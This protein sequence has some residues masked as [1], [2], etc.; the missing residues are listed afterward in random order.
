MITLLAIGKIKDKSYAELEDKYLKRLAHYTKCQII[1]LPDAQESSVT[2]R[3]SIEAQSLLK[4]IKPDDLAVLLD[5]KGKLISS[6]KLAEQIQQDQNNSVKNTV[7][8]I[9]GPFGVD[10]QI[11]QRANRTLALGALTFTHELARIILLEQLY[12]AHTILKGEKYHHD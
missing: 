6:R 3:I 4:K 10:K 1:N 9:G 7:Y 2:T 5:E 8:I 11:K 12:R